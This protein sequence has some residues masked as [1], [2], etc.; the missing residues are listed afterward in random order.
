LSKISIS[1]TPLD[2]L[3][4]QYNIVVAN[5]LAEPLVEMSGDIKER[6]AESGS[7]ILSGILK[8]KADSVVAAYVGKGLKLEERLEDGDWSALLFKR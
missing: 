3:T 2:A 1:S 4:G 6:L 7:L 8:E 5:I